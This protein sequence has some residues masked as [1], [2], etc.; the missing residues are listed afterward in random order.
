MVGMTVPSRSGRPARCSATGGG[1]RGRGRVRITPQ[2]C[3]TLYTVTLP[4]LF[5]AEV[6]PG[7]GAAAIDHTSGGRVIDLIRHLIDTD[8]WSLAQ[9]RSR[10]QQAQASPARAS[11]FQQRWLTRLDAAL[12]H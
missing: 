3:A 1:R 10:L 7:L 6:R 9:T 4:R 2:E 5:L 8:I 12:A 11:A